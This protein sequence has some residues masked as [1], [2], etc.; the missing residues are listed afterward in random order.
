GADDFAFLIGHHRAEGSQPPVQVSRTIVQRVLKEGVSI[1]SNDV[2]DSPAYSAA[3][4]LREMQIRS[5]LA[6]PLVA[7][8]AARGAIYLETRD[9]K[10]AYTGHKLQL[11]AVMAGMA[12]LALEN[13]RLIERLEQENERL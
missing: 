4:S 8:D 2:L 3:E 10:V 6:V 9:K 11:L 13:A 7:A 5:V 12:S 1:L